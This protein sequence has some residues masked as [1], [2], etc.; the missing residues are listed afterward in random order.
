[1]GGFGGLSAAAPAAQLSTATT[2]TAS[3]GLGGNTVAPSFSFGV[4]SAGGT[5]TSVASNQ[6][7]GQGNLYSYDTYLNT[8]P[9]FFINL[10][11]GGEAIM[12]EFL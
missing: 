10:E 6:A 12:D 7:A 3:L 8:L 9:I 4:S 11:R 1:M 2:T 5:S